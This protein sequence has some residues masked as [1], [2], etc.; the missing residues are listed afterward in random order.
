MMSTKYFLVSLVGF[1]MITHHNSEQS[2]PWLCH[3]HWLISKSS[4]YRIKSLVAG[5]CYWARK[6]S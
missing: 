1:R 5:D 3:H 6:S 2:F 4:K